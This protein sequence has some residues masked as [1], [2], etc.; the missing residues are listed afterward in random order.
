MRAILQRVRRGSVTVDGQLVAEIGPG[1]V[2]L[3]GVTHGD[4]PAEAR[5]LRRE[6]EEVKLMTNPGLGGQPRRASLR[7]RL[8]YQLGHE[9][10]LRLAHGRLGPVDDVVHQPRAVRQRRVLRIDV[11]GVLLI[12]QE[13]VAAAGAACEI[14]LRAHLDVAVGPHDREP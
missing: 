11:A 12:H 8:E 5:K 9:E 3:L 10:R 13:Q 6:T 7:L 1:Y 14:D 4:G 2:I